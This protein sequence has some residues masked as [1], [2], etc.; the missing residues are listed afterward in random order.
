MARTGTKACSEIPLPFFIG[1]I[2]N[3][4]NSDILIHNL[5]IQS[6]SHHGKSMS[7]K[8]AAAQSSRQQFIESSGK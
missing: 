3:Y 7:E 4:A 8:M 6:Q 5:G 2:H 1:V